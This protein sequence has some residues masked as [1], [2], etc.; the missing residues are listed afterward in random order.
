[1][2]KWFGETVPEIKKTLLDTTPFPEDVINLLPEYFE[3]PYQ[4]KMVN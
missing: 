4:T 2:N 1:M 3:Y